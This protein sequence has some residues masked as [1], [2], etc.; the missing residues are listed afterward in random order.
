MKN[1]KVSKTIYIIKNLKKLK[2][3]ERLAIVLK[4]NNAE[5]LEGNFLTECLKINIRKKKFFSNHYLNCYTDKH[6]Y[7]HLN[8]LPVFG[9]GMLKD[10][11]FPKLY[12]VSCLTNKA[13][14]GEGM[15][16]Y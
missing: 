12:L 15:R 6:S 7:I 2:T 16:S 9:V 10:N 3:E 5:N 4:N 11:L 14:S 13:L 1:Y 8:R